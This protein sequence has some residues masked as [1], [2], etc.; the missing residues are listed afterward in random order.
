VICRYRVQVDVHQ[1]ARQVL[2]GDDRRGMV[3]IFPERPAALL[4]PIEA[5]AGASGNELHAGGDLIAAT[6]EHE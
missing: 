2:F 6:V 1:I 4:A 5:L 3:A